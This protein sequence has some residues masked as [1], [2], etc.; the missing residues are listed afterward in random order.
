MKQNLF[1]DI[2][3]T[4]NYPVTGHWFITPNFYKLVGKTD[5][6]LLLSAINKK[7]YILDEKDVFTEEEEFDMFCNFYN[8][9]LVE[10]GYRDITTKLVHALAYDCVYND[11]KIKFYPDV[12]RSL[13]KLSK[14]Y[15]LYVISDAWPS[16]YRILK[17]NKIMKYFKKVF[18]S[19]ELGFTKGDKK[20]FDIALEGIDSNDEN[21]FIDDRYDLLQ[22]S[23]EYGFIPI[24]IDRDKNK[25]TDYIEIEK[26]KDLFKVLKV[27]NKAK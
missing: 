16:T 24:I 12:K 6:K 19:S 26:M 17:N 25:E 22:I 18:V 13:R 7:K 27:Y 9:V 21:F 10:I 23:E 5:E 1:F 4:L 3:N 14:K 8:S 20:L 11:K 2:G 15:N